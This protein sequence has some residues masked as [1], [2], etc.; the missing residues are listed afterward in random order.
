MSDFIIKKR[1]IVL[2]INNNC[3][4]SEQRMEISRLNFRNTHK[5]Y[6]Q[7]SYTFAATKYHIFNQ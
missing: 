5:I 3:T 7:N 4:V 1:H 2:R 6:F